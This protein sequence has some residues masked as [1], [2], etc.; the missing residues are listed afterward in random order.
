MKYKIPTLLAVF[1]LI[2][3]AQLAIEGNPNFFSGKV[4]LILIALIVFINLLDFGWVAV[5]SLLAGFILDLY[6]G[7]PFGLMLA[8]IFAVAVGCQFLFI[9]F[10]TNFSFYSSLA[11]S[12][13][14]VLMYHCLLFLFLWLASVWGLA[15]WSLDW[16]YLIDFFYQ[17]LT[18]A[19]FSGLS[20]F[21]ISSWFKQ[22]RPMFLK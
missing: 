17:L 8:L 22:L 7:L 16:Q 21:M 3:L 10:F 20:Y 11:L 9:N 5:F 19:V 4:N 12:L 1:L 6:S 14:A 18:A 2:S 15:D 13:L